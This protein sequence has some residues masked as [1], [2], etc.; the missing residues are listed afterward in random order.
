MDV[1]LSVLVDSISASQVA[2]DFD[3]SDHQITLWFD[4]HLNKKML[5]LFDLI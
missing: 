4:V 5:Y 2:G 1:D 3:L